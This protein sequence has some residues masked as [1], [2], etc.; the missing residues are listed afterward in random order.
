MPIRI[1][2]LDP[3]GGTQ[4]VNIHRA[5]SPMNDEAN[6]PAPIATVTGASF[7]VDDAAVRNQLYYYRLS[8]L[9]Q[10]G[11]ADM[12]ITPN[13]PMASMPYTGPGPQTLLRGDWECGYFGRLPMGSLITSQELV[14]ILGAGTDTAIADNEWLKY[15][16]KGNIFFF[17]KYAI[18]HTIS[19]DTVY[20]AGMV[21]GDIDPAQWPAIAKSSWGTITQ[22]KRITIGNHVLTIRN[23]TSRANPLNTGSVIPT[24]YIGGEFDQFLALAGKN[25]NY[26][27]ANGRMQFDDVVYPSLVGMTTDLSATGVQVNRGWN[28]AFDTLNVTLGGTGT[29]SQH[30]WRPLLVLNL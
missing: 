16:Y 25:R 14:S 29:H 3:N 22:K 6:L 5:T 20:K 17:P 7:Y 28:D 23:P 4:P 21:F 18:A 9:G 2:W 26:P 8:S 12:I 1:D 10:A 11:A 13:K 15:V 19:W 30:A 24:D 27:D